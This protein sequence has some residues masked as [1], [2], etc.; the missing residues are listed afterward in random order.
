V[1][2]RIPDNGPKALSGFRKIP[3]AMF[4]QDSGQDLLILPNYRA[5][6]RVKAQ[7]YFTEVKPFSSAV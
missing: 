5:Q 3:C 7:R 1:A 4:L 6:R 2:G